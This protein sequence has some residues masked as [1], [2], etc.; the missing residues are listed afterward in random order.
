MFISIQIEEDLP[1][2]P[3][4]ITFKQSDGKNEI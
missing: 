3:S 4:A 1:I 2:L